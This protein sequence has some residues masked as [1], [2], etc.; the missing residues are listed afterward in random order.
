MIT[1]ADLT[2][3]M[4]RAELR[5]STTMEYTRHCLVAIMAETYD[6]NEGPAEARQRVCDAINAKFALYCAEL[7]LGL[8][9]K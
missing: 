1:P 6:D 9:A 8:D 4:V 7:A 2:E 5:S 3:E